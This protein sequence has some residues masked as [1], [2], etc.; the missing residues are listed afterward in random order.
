MKN[1]TKSEIA[2]RHA[3]RGWRV[4]PL[5]TPSDDGSCSC[6]HSTCGK[7]TGKHPRIGEWQLAATTDEATIRD[8][9]HKWPNANIGI[10]TGKE[11][12]IIVLDIDGPNGEKIVSQYGAEPS[13]TVITGKGRQIYFKHPGFKVKN[14][15][16]V[17]PELDSRGDG[18]YVCAAGSKHLSGKIYYFEEGAHPD[19][20]SLADAPAWWLNV[21]RDIGLKETKQAASIGPILKSKRNSTLASMAGSLRNLGHD[22]VIIAQALIAFN[23]RRCVPP[24][25]DDQVRKIASS[26]GKYEEGDPTSG[27]KVGELAKKIMRQENFV[28]SPISQDGKGV[29]LMLYKDG[30]Y[31]SNGES[32]ARSIAARGLG[33]A[34]RDE[35][36]GGVAAVI[37]EFTKKD[38]TLLNPSAKT[39]I[40]VQNGMLNWATGELL[41]HD[42][43]YLSTVQLPIEWH[44]DAKSDLL[45]KFLTEVFPSNALSLA[46]EMVG[47]FAIPSTVYQKAFMLCGPGSNGK[48]VYLQLI[49]FF[50]GAENISRVSLHD[51]EDSPFAAAELQG[52]L[53]NVYPEPRRHEAPKN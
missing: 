41:P 34:V 18:G 42:P 40:N 35:T 20:V 52:K 28:A 26:Y 12:G 11:S 30:A 3:A 46:E 14:S 7:T 2:L 27:V 5:H 33:N 47:Y 25:E 31:R 13:P 38:D 24:L 22:E 43:A 51:L 10:A 23:A 45:D 21:V 15:V 8:W 1:L 49:G 19:A 39:L 36:I 29:V 37:K 32:V 44:P 50:I 48:S 16:G 9:W 4:F 6:G 53:L 17:Y